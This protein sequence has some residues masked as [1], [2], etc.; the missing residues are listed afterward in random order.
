[1]A[2]QLVGQIDTKRNPVRLTEPKGLSRRTTEFRRIDLVPLAEEAQRKRES[3]RRNRDCKSNLD[4]RHI[5][6]ANA[7]QI[8]W[9]E[10]RTQLRGTSSHNE[11]WTDVRR[12]A[13]K[14]VQEL[15][16]E[17]G[18]R[19]TDEEGAADGFKDCGAGMMLA[20]SEILEVE[21]VV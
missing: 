14:L 10:N 17:A 12:G 13:S 19:D 8:A 15:V 16:D 9:G 5:R 2:P 11:A 7:R 6:N 3:H 20:G 1:M 21:D 4:T 18:L